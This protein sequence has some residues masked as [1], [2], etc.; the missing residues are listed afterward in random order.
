MKRRIFNS[1]TGL[2][3][4]IVENEE[5]LIHI[6]VLIHPITKV[7][8][9][10]GQSQNV[11]IRIANHLSQLTSSSKGS[12]IKKINILK[13]IVEQGVFPEFKILETTIR[14]FA[15]ERE[16]YWINEYKNNNI[17]LANGIVRIQKQPKRR[18]KLDLLNTI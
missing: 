4:T 9:Y 15:A 17:E 2:T 8:F 12:S 16:K 11:I 7:H 18:V 6:Y 10:V 13:E 14:R 5:D 3:E 1:N